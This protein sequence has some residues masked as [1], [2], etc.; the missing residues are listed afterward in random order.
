MPVSD[1]AV[2]RLLAR[3]NFSSRAV[4]GAL[5]SPESMQ[6]QTI[7]IKIML[8]RIAVAAAAAVDDHNKDK[9]DEQCLEAFPPALVI[10][11][12]QSVRTWDEGRKRE[13]D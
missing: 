8:A 6:Q 4:T 7:N 3:N 5:A 12:D 10:N 2:Y 9:F 1:A 11:A 13:R